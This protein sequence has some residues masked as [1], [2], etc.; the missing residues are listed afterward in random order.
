LILHWHLMTPSLPRCVFSSF[1]YSNHSLKEPMTSQ[2]YKWLNSRKSKLATDVLQAIKKFFDKPEFLKQSAKI[3]EYVRWALRGDGP[4]HYQIPTPQSCS[5]PHDDTG[6]IV[7]GRFYTVCLVLPCLLWHVRLLMVSC[8]LNS[9]P[10]SPCSIS[11]TL[12][13]LSFFWH[14]TQ[15][16]HQKVYMPYFLL[17]YEYLILSMM[18]IPDHCHQVERS[19]MTFA[20]GTYAEPPLF[21]HKNC[22][23]P[24][25]VF[26]GHVDRVSERC[27]GLILEL[28]KNTATKEKDVYID[29]SAIS[30]YCE[31][32]YIPSSPQKA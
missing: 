3:R 27:W 29:Q 20:T 23:R 28:E 9:S 11:G 32:L 18:S 2:A 12:K 6:Y 22:W 16:A 30:A 15:N 8:S 13:A 25:R 4:A 7:S 31:D 14:S 26:L 1:N 24:L 10:Q 5:V 21:A 17:W 19:F